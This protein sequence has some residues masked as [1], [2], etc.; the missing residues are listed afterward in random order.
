MEIFHGLLF[1]LGFF[2]SI[3]LLALV[4]IS[5]VARWKIFAKANQPGW[6]SIIPIYNALIFLRIIGKPCGGYFCFVFPWLTLSLSSWPWT[7]Y[8]KVLARV[9]GLRLDYFCF[10]SSLNLFLLLVTRNTLA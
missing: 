5:I 7:C 1:G 10:L 4:I 2:F 8:L 6:A 3:V 9:C